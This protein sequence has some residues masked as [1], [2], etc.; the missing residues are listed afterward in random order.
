M[1]SEDADWFDTLDFKVYPLGPSKTPWG[2]SKRLLPWLKANVTNYDAVIV[3]GLWMYHLHAAW[4][5]LYKTDVPYFVFTHGMLD[6]WFKTTYP[7]KHLKKHLFWHWSEYPAL[8]DAKG[9]L[10]TTEQEKILARD[11]FKR[12]RCNEVVVNYGTAYPDFNKEEV[13]SLFL[14]SFPEL[15]GKELYLYLSRI[16]PKKGCDLLIN[17]F[18]KV[19]KV[20][21][22]AQLVM[23]GPDHTGWKH[24]LLEIA[25]KNGISNRITWTGML[26]NEMKW[27]AYYSSE[28]FCLTSHQENFGIVVAEAMACGLPVLI[29]KQVNIWHEVEE[30]HAG[31]V[32]TDDQ[33]GADELLEK[34]YS[35]STEE[36][37]IM[38]ENAIVSFTENF[39]IGNAIKSLITV[40]ES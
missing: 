34:W 21:S 16:H 30:S 13:S 35:T 39:E 8:R 6:P 37:K 38:S 1:D 23:A 25:N 9:V 31:F 20:N 18:T 27:G 32:S 11:S 40:L 26:K 22:N 14:D 28:V 15:K 17:A 24:D 33:D 19:A 2:Y 3:R 4:K 7:L 29:T 5:A 10:F 12:Y 36:K